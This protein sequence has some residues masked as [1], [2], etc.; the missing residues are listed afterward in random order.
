[1][2]LI[3]IMFKDFF[4][5]GI[6]N[7]GSKIN[8][9]FQTQLKIKINELKQ[10]QTFIKLT[11]EFILIFLQIRV[12]SQK[13]VNINYYND[14]SNDEDDDINDEDVYVVEKEK[15]EQQ[16]LQFNYCSFLN[17]INVKV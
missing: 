2:K 15:C 5:I 6:T 14:N 10:I 13:Q 1:M 11:Q 4:N 16:I 12:K 9:I 17:T 7:Q 3:I 8:S